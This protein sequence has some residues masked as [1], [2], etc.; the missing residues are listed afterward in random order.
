[1]GT[2]MDPEADMLPAGLKPNW[3]ASAEMPNSPRTV[4][5]L[6]V[7]FNWDITNC[8]REAKAIARG[9][10]GFPFRATLHAKRQIGYVVETHLNARQL[11]QRLDDALEQ[12][13][14]QNAW[15]FTPGADVASVAQMDPLTD[16]IANAWASVRRYNQRLH[17]KRLPPHLFER[18]EPI[19]GEPKGTVI[20]RILDRH[21]LDRH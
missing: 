16:H 19:P 6:M 8:E 10:Y 4:L 18:T 20:T 11:V 12:G 13:C 21:P 15:A 3:K 14:I 7:A 5:V 1:M 9:L 2:R 17:L